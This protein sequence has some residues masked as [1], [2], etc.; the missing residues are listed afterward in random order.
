M[1]R[2]LLSLLFFVFIAELQLPMPLNDDRDATHSHTAYTSTVYPLP[3]MDVGSEANETR[4]WFR[5]IN[6]SQ[7]M[8]GRRRTKPCL[9]RKSVKGSVAD[10][11]NEFYNENLL[12]Q[13][14]ILSFALRPTSML[15][16]WRSKKTKKKQKNMTQF[17]LINNRCHRRHGETESDVYL[18]F[19]LAMIS[20][21]S[22][23][24]RIDRGDDWF[25]SEIR[26]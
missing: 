4:N 19:Q 2:A 16:D 10:F 24:L 9:A 15:D 11:D 25:R 6:S 18:S 21:P 23:C 8:T 12:C 20:I 26:I 13:I 3:L 22:R 17:N 1:V 14:N 5:F 7:T